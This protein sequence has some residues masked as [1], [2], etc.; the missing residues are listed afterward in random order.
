DAPRLNALSKAHN[1]FL[2]RQMERLERSPGFDANIIP[3]DINA[4][5][6]QAI[7]QPSQFGFTNVTEPCLNQQA[8][9]LCSNP[10]QYLFWDRIHPTT[11]AHQ[12]I[13]SYAFNNLAALFPPAP[14]A[15]FAVPESASLAASQLE[16][17][18]FTAL[19]SAAPLDAS[20][21]TTWRSPKQDTAAVPE[22]AATLG[23]FALAGWGMS[24]ARRRK[25]FA[26][27]PANTVEGAETPW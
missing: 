18:A 22:P 3:L 27:R 11:A 4:L 6:N 26:N 12:L 8:G 7:N 16:A 1:N 2:F 23:L 10:N 14:A 20:D 17:P 9:T 24:Q 5:F 13:G 25:M 21:L 15:A 19:K